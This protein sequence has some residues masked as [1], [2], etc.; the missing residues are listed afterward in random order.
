MT[1]RC[2][3]ATTAGSGPCAR[4]HTGLGDPH[5][6]GRTTCAL[7]FAGGT[8]VFYKPRSLAIADR[9]LGLLSTLNALG[10]DPAFPLR[11][12]HDGGDHGWEAAVG[13]P[14]AASA[15][16]ARCYYRQQGG[17][18]AIL[19]LLAG[20]DMHHENV[21]AAG[22]D[23]H[24][25]DLEVLLQAPPR[26][27]V[28]GAALGRAALDAHRCIL[29]TGLLPFRLAIGDGAIDVSGLGAGEAQ[30]TPVRVAQ[31]ADGGTDRMRIVREFATVAP[32]APRPG[33]GMPLDRHGP[34]LEQGFRATYDLL[35][36]HRRDIAA[37]LEG[38]AGCEVRRVLRPTLVYG[39][40]RE[41]MRHPD[42]LRDESAREELAGRLWA[43]VDAGDPVV[44]ALTAHERSQLLDDDVPRFGVRADETAISGVAGA[45][46]W[47]GLDEA[48]QRLAMLG[49]ADRDLQLAWLR[50]ALLP[51]RLHAL[52]GAGPSEQPVGHG[53][54]P[55]AP[56][57]G[58]A[59]LERE[60]TALGD[61]LIATATR[62]SD[63]SL[64]WLA[65]APAGPDA[66]EVALGDPSLYG[67]LSGIALYLATL[68]ARTGRVRF[69]EAAEGALATAEAVLGG[70]PARDASAF[71][72]AAGRV[73]A[74]V[75][76]AELHGDP[77]QL[78]EAVAAARDLG[79]VIDADDRLD[80]VSG[81]AGTALI[82]CGLF[83]RTGDPEVG[84]LARRCVR[85]LLATATPQ[86]AGVGWTVPV[87]GRPVAGFAHGAAGFALALGRA[88][89]VLAVP[90]TAAARGP[91]A[92]A[93]PGAADAAVAPATASAG[94]PGAAAEPGPRE[95][96]L[97]TAVADL[98]PRVLAFERSLWD[99]RR[100]G[101][102][103]L[104][105]AGD[106]QPLAVPSWC[107]GAAGILVGRLGL[108]RDLADALV[109]VEIERAI[110]QTVDHGLR[111][112]HS[113]CHGVLGDADALLLAA[114]RD[115]RPELRATAERAAARAVAERRR[116]GA[117]RCGWGAVE[118]P[119]LLV[120]L[121]GIGY[122]L[123]RIAEPS[124]LP[125]VLELAS[126]GASA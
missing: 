16:A 92:T 34:D 59:A 106:P 77:R 50:T 21:V 38:F 107:N 26:R 53:P 14:I 48:R 90:A 87:A 89:D 95:A 41:A 6:G 56:R 122:G 3:S 61:R 88:R 124:G 98:V 81:V 12:I 32:S 69:A 10:A 103:D 96:D 111:G 93:E 18:L 57:I 30:R 71:L 43:G 15:A 36:E 28:D 54:G 105:L 66:W 62:G 11:W 83:E 52:P 118:V 80:V 68:A 82:L 72:G 79:G 119:G 84:A 113:L 31:V 40:L 115:D 101:W 35:V 49:D 24:L 76:L 64:T 67:G 42:A 55:G 58:P 65:P 22:A 20:A 45:L 37:Q 25:V 110:A 117:W 75:R 116:D 63:G 9:F 102:L 70:Q 78:A 8:R 27:A 108:P 44:R 1:G 73:Y 97:A 121:A 17:Y 39:L 125:S 7:H 74:L 19:H 85:R 86:P 46:P 104:R 100:A 5:G 114:Q 51:R 120:G 91:G 112:D 109:D 2:S 60:A 99:E 23:A 94:E 33:A 29:R 126:G 123:L 13:G 4:I 47:S